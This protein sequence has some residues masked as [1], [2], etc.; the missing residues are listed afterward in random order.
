V[1]KQCNKIISSSSAHHAAHVHAHHT[2]FSLFGVVVLL[3]LHDIC[4][5]VALVLCHDFVH[6]SVVSDVFVASVNHVALQKVTG[7]HQVFVPG[8][9]GSDKIVNLLLVLHVATVSRLDVDNL[10][11]LVELTDEEAIHD[12]VDYHPFEF[13]LVRDLDGF[14]DIAVLESRLLASLVALLQV[15]SLFVSHLRDSNHL[16]LA[17]HR[18][19]EGDV[20]G[21]STNVSL[22]VIESEKLHSCQVPWCGLL[23]VREAE[24]LSEDKDLG[25]LKNS[26]H[27]FFKS[28][29]SGSLALSKFLSHFLVERHIFS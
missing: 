11:V 15:L 18:G 24:E 1:I 2:S 12:T 29:A 10:V 13:S 26:N 7:G 8:F 5:H 19:S 25:V 6:F 27:S 4:L 9:K 20:V 14:H 23:E 28:F 3:S 22:V 21:S 16:Q 17:H